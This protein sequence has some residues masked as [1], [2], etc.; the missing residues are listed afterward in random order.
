MTSDS[1]EILFK[2]AKAPEL[3]A[4]KNCIKRDWSQHIIEKYFKRTTERHAKYDGDLLWLLTFDDA[5]TSKTLEYIAKNYQ[6]FRIEQKILDSDFAGQILLKNKFQARVWEMILSDVLFSVG[7]LL[8]KDKSGADFLLRTDS[9]QHIQIEAVTPN[10]A[11][12]PALQ[13]IKP[14]FDHDGFF[15]HGANINEAELP[16]VLRFLKGFD[17]KAKKGYSTDIPLI[18]A[19]NTGVVVG[20]STL[21]DFVLR[22]SLFGLGCATISLNTDGTS[23]A[24]LQQTPRIDKGGGSFPVARFRDQ[25]FTHVSGVIYS[26]QKPHSLTPYGHGWHNSGLVY[27]PNPMAKNPADVRFD[28]MHTMSVTPVEYHEQKAETEFQSCVV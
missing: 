18:I 12:D 3:V 11:D 10:E 4:L 21:D 15:S 6:K 20:L 2:D 8:P 28:C 25:R 26:S 19:I 17:A 24:G 1:I 13:T 22:Q 23:S 14:T 7:E 9:G 27:V 5:Y 16:I